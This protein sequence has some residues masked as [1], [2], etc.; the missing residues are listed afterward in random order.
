MELFNPWHF[1]IKGV[2][3]FMY[4]CCQVPIWS[5]GYLLIS[6]AEGMLLGMVGA[7]ALEMHR[8]RADG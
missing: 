1:Q 7:I 3:G 2:I 8:R 5:P 4:R 6:L